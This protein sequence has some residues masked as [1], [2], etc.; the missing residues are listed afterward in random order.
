M[1]NLK[2]IFIP[3]LAI[4]FTINTVYA[5]T[6]Y[7]FDSLRDE[8]NSMD[9]RTADA[10][11]IDRKLTCLARNIYFESASEP[12][13]GK[14]AVAQVVMN[15]TQDPDFP[16]DVCEVVYQKNKVV[17]KT[18]CQFSWYC[19]KPSELKIKSVEKYEESMEAAKKVMLEGFRLPTLKTALYYHADYIKP[20]WD[21]KFVVQIGHHRFFSKEKKNG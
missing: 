2:K 9:S 6:A 11:D 16:A 4:I 10:K 18:V 7:R 17:E 12:I 1:L 19:T 15:R 14:I 8:I 20:H 13:E 21:K 5:I 3:L